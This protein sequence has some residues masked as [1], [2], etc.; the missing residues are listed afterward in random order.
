[1]LTQVMRMRFFDICSRRLIENEH[2]HEIHS[3]DSRHS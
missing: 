3:Y 2:I 1:M